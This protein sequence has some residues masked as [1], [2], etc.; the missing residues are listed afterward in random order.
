MGWI[1]GIG[2]VV[3][4][5]AVI[6]LIVYWLNKDLWDSFCDLGD[7]IGLDDKEDDMSSMNDR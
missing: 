2:C 1:I 3:A 6:W 4:V 5:V 7:F